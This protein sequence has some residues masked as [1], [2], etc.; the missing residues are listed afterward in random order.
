MN[1]KEIEIGNH[2]LETAKREIARLQNEKLRTEIG[3]KNDQLNT[4]TMQVMNTNTKIQDALHNILIKLEK[5][6]SR[7]ELKRIIRT[8]EKDMIKNDSWDQ[9]AHHFDQVHGDYLR[10]LSGSNIRLTPREIKLAAF[11]RMNLSSK[12]ISKMMNITVRSVELARHRLRKKLKL[13]RDQNLVEYLIAL[14]SQ[15]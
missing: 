11:L 7:D 5:G 12:E 15:K 10:K 13:D 8:I 3:L 9:F 1:D 14:D 2:Y 4:I 6:G